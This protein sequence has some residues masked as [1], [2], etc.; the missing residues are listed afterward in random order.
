MLEILQRIPHLNLGLHFDVSKMAEEVKQ[1]DTFKNYESLDAGNKELYSQ[2]WSGA[3]LISL[4]GSVFSDMS[5]LKVF[6]K[7]TP[8]PTELANKCPYLMSIIDKL[9]SKNERTRIMRIAPEGRLDWHSHVIHQ[10]QN[11]RRLVVQIP[12]YVPEGF[13]YSVIHFRDLKRIQKGEEVIQYKKTY[14]QGQ[15]YIFNSYHP[16]NV[17]NPSTEF[18]ITL[19]TYISLDNDKSRTLVEKAVEKYDGPFLQSIS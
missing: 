18:R 11:P 16:H 14:K 4:D 17:F 1:I 10:K 12:I 13:T 9:G 6:P 7:V 2:N 15:A 3:S 8:K 5:E 19:M